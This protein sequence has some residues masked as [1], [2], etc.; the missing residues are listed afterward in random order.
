MKD[1]N[2]SVSPNKKNQFKSVSPNN[3]NNFK[4]FSPTIRTRS[5]SP[6]M[7]LGERDSLDDIKGSNRLV[8]S[9]CKKKTYRSRTQLENRQTQTNSSREF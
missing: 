1:F 6:R 8:T 5:R 3:K 2:K 7:L 9:P 4:E